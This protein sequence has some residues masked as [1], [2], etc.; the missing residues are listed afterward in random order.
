MNEPTP[1][2]RL[3][4]RAVLH[5]V[6]PMVNGLL[7]VSDQTELPAFHRVMRLVLGWKSEIGYIVRVHGQEFNSFPRKTRLKA[8]HELKLPRQE[9]FLYI[10]DTL[11]MWE[12]DIRVLD[13]EEG[14]EGDQHPLCLSGRGAAP[15]E[16][17]GGP[18][19]YR[20]MLKRQRE[21][22]AM[23]D[24]VRREAGIE[25]YAQAWPDEPTETWDLLRTALD[26]GL[27]NIDQRL[28]AYGPLQPD[29]FDLKETNERLRE[30][31]ACARYRLP[32]VQKEGRITPRLL[33]ALA[34]RCRRAS[35]EVA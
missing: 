18:T 21:G 9:K 4:L 28:Q 16:H 10:C 35:A 5:Q 22:A 31:Q 20:L 15:P 2:K 6:S 14:V 29:L 13:I 25:L 17:C 7:S 12:W 11:H 23:S 24:P 33:D 32:A 30:L 34:I 27:R 19:G 3:I 8:L 1:F 26:E